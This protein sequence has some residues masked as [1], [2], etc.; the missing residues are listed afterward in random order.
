MDLA[1]ARAFLSTQISHGQR[2]KLR[3][4]ELSGK[5]PPGRCLTGFEIC[6]VFQIR[7]TAVPD[8]DENA[9]KE[10]R[11]RYEQK[12]LWKRQQIEEK[13]HDTQCAKKCVCR[14]AVQEMHD[15]EDWALMNFG[16]M[17]IAA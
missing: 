2:A 9:M 15:W 5:L 4:Y 10:L 16:S 8:I 6:K 12:V 3:A 17:G 13:A 7:P 11:Q 1:V 14:T